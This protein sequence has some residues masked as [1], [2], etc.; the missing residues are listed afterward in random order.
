MN[1]S[2]RLPYLTALISHT[3]ADGVVIQLSSIDRV[4][5]AIISQNLLR[6]ARS[7]TILPLTIAG[8]DTY[9][10]GEDPANSSHPWLLTRPSLCSIFLAT[11]TG[12]SAAAKISKLLRHR[13]LVYKSHSGFENFVLSFITL[14]LNVNLPQP[15]CSGL[16]QTV[17]DDQFGGRTDDDLF[18]DDFEPVDSEAVQGDQ[19]AP[20]GSKE[21]APSP[22]SVP[23][24]ATEESPQTSTATQPQKSLANSRFADKSPSKN[25][26]ISSSNVITKA[27]RERHR[28]SQNTSD[29]NARLQ[30]GANPRQKLTEEELSVKMEE[31][32]LLSAEKT[33]KFE[34]AEKD[35]KEHAEAYA[36]GMEAARKRRAQ[37]AEKKRRGEEDRKRMEDE[38]AKNRERKLKA[39]GAKESSWD[40]GKEDMAE[41]ETRRRFKGANGAIGRARRGGSPGE[42]LGRSVQEMPDVDRFLE[43][44]YRDR[45]IRGRGKGFRGGQGSSSGR[46]R[47]SNGVPASTLTKRTLP[48]AEEFPAL[49]AAIG[50]AKTS[51]EPPSG[52]K[53]PHTELW[54][55]KSSLSRS[56]GA[57]WD[58]E[59]AALD[60]AARDQT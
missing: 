22:S 12:N 54:A 37:E 15:I 41:E 52:S 60:E 26:S 13:W 58:E 36:K 57:K 16:H 5:A 44:R 21:P 34:K 45:S 32:K 56:H 1:I 55:Q 49:P 7:S 11:R 59:M 30:S 39:I 29:P 43:D 24:L 8:R 3:Q 17:M 18:Y 50:K 19:T 10:D 27:L 28:G 9:L 48:Q 53:P 6:R 23:N 47:I 4:K 35:E 51:L 14:A 46:D 31:M 40:E 42:R 38:R 33:R 2:R 20:S 25:S